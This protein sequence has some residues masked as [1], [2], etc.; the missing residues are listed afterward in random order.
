MKVI[1]SLVAVMNLISD[2]LIFKVMVKRW[3]DQGHISC[4]SCAGPDVYTVGLPYVTVTLSIKFNAC[5]LLHV[6]VWVNSIQFNL[7]H[8]LCTTV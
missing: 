5:I 4:T 3:Y 7:H 6:Y 8:Y 2:S 1:I